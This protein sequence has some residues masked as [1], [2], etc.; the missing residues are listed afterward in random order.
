MPRLKSIAQATFPHTAIYTGEFVSGLDGKMR[1]LQEIR[2]ELYG[3]LVG[4]L[5]EYSKDL[6]LYLCMESPPVWNRS[7]G[8]APA[9]NWE[10]KQ[11]LDCSLSGCAQANIGPVL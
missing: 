11:L 9:S 7:M 4:W 10:L 5:R 6:C 1:Y 2:L 3:R 8:S